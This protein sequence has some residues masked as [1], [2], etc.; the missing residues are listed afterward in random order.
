MK[1]CLTETTLRVYSDGELFAGEMTA[2]ASHLAVCKSCASAAKEM[3]NGI[4][5][6]NQMFA[7][8]FSLPVPAARLHERLKLAINASPAPKNGF[9]TRLGFDL[10]AT[11]LRLSASLKTMPRPV[12]GFASLIIAFLL[13]G[14]L[15]LKLDLGVKPAK[16]ETRALN[17]A[18]PAVPSDTRA[19]DGALRSDAVQQGVPSQDKSSDAAAYKR[20]GRKSG[21]L[22]LFRDSG[23]T[24]A[25]RQIFTE[26]RESSPSLARDRL[27]RGERR[28]LNDIAMLTASLE[29]GPKV[30]RPILRVEYER[31]LAVVDV[32]INATRRVVLENPE[33]M[34]AS[35]FLLAAY[36]SKVNLLRVVASRAQTQSSNMED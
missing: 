18:G 11:F 23:Q 13:I 32:A 9:Y 16:D 19:S 8:L 31:N 14:A 10:S 34:N 5:T 6:F 28:Y 26:R 25:K 22:K 33:D 21:G 30:L 2:V 17:G 15:V 3:E 20:A 7:P 24:A 35:K 29:G 4:E 1:G 27:I 12:V 36:R